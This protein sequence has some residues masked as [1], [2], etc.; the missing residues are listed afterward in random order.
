MKWKNTDIL[1]LT[2]VVSL[3]AFFSATPFLYAENSV[4]E[5]TWKRNLFALDNHVDENLDDLMEGF[6]GET[7]DRKPEEK[8]EVAPIEHDP[9]QKKVS[10]D[11]FAKMAAS[12]NFAHDAPGVGEIDWRGLSKLRGELQLE[13]TA[14]FSEDWQGFISGKG[15]YD[16][17]YTLNGRAN[18]T[19]D[20]LD[21]YEDEVELRECY[22]LGKIS[23][24]LDIKIGRQIVV[25]GKSDTIRI[26]DVLNPLDTREPGLTDLEDLRLPIT[27]TKIDYYIG[28]WNVTGIAIHEIR[29][30]K[31]P[32]FGSDF[33]PLPIP[34]PSEDKPGHGGRNTEYAASARGTFSGWDIAFFYADIFWDIPHVE[35][36]SILPLT[37]KLKYDDVT[38]VGSAFNIAIGNWILKAEAAFIDGLRYFNMPEEDYTRIDAMGGIEYY[39]FDDTTIIIE[40]SNRHINGYDDELGELPDQAE[41]NEFQSVLRASR[42]FMNETLELEGLLSFF[43]IN[44]NDGKFQRF[45]LA[46]DI[47]DALEIKGGVLLYQSGDLAVFSDVGDNDRFFLDLKYSF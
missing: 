6:E 28:N 31:F 8:G 42:T 16:F 36:M 29:F 13:L 9:Q 46:Y 10:L 15:S 1:I 43:G 21:E 30:N 14:K 34:L 47:T 26:A 40:A 12:Y 25:W 4:I 2:V 45:S 11:G 38:M 41:K 7:Q 19:S 22:V 18:Y 35:T 32:A 3:A 23:Q 39:G 44:G 20:V 27:M 33:F 5:G 37:F 17:A 24:N